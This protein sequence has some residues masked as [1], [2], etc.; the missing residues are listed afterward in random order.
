MI[1]ENKKQI[2]VVRE[3]PQDIQVKIASDMILKWNNVEGASVRDTLRLKGYL[4][5]NV[6]C[7]WSST[8]GIYNFV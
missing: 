8:I 3:L 2:S 4:E 1:R 7:A 6:G 5:R